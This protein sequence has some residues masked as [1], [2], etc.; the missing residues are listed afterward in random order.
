MMEDGVREYHS[1]LQK[2][3]TMQARAREVEHELAAA[4]RL[5]KLP[6]MHAVES[7]SRRIIANPPTDFASQRNIIEG[8]LDLRVVYF[9]GM[10]EISGRVP[11]PVAREKSV[12]RSGK[13]DGLAD[14]LTGRHIPGLPAPY[15]A[16]AGE[17][18]G[19]RVGT[20]RYLFNRRG[21]V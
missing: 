17:R 12:D 15:V 5:V 13:G 4:G 20:Q 11:V 10:L 3:R 14:L 21:P 2:I 19:P 8:I 9:E 18:R 6:P 16:G 1:G 7:Y